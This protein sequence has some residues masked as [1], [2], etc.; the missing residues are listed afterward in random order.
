VYFQ[1]HWQYAIL[2]LLGRG[3]KLGSFLKVGDELYSSDTADTIYHNPEGSPPAACSA[4]EKTQ[5]RPL[6]SNL[7]ISVMCDYVIEQDPNFHI[8]SMFVRSPFVVARLNRA[9]FFVK[10]KRI[11]I[12]LKMCLLEIAVFGCKS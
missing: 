3:T 11:L 8:T 1:T 4:L 12:F 6:Q 9:S 7:A 2:P 10:C 5:M